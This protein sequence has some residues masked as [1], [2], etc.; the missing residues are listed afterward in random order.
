M[1][2]ETKED[3]RAEFSDDIKSDPK[4]CNDFTGGI[5][6]DSTS[7][8]ERSSSVQFELAE[9]RMS[10]I[11]GSLLP[12]AVLM[13]ERLLFLW[14]VY[15]GQDDLWT[16]LTIASIICTVYYW[17]YVNRVK[18]KHKVELFAAFKL[19]RTPSIPIPVVAFLAYSPVATR[20]HRLSDLVGTLLYWRGLSGRGMLSGIA[21]F[22]VTI[23]FN[24]AVKCFAAGSSSYIAHSG[25]A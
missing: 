22:H 24:F 14:M 5:S 16:L 8:L 23:S 15:E 25:D 20:C 19:S 12:L 13:G 3:T 9:S 2:D 11:L 18:K 10:A 17:A 7:L 6:A 21:G 4:V 1:R